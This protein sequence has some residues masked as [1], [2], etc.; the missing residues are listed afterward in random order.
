MGFQV[1]VNDTDLIHKS[2]APNPVNT[3]CCARGFKSSHPVHFL[4]L[5]N[6]V[7]N[8][9]H[10]RLL[11][12]KFS[13]SSHK[14]NDWSKSK[15]VKINSQGREGAEGAGDVYWRH[16]KVGYREIEMLKVIFCIDDMQR[17]RLSIYACIY[18]LF[19]SSVLHEALPFVITWLVSLSLILESNISLSLSWEYY[20]SPK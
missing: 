20:F 10:F 9:A 2:L 5:Y 18:S 1:S 6:T 12:D 3:A 14:E 4:P 19:L 17:R 11:S 8:W 13:R 16:R 7:L 15:D